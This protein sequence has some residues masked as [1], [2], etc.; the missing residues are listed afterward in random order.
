MGIAANPCFVALL[1][2]FCAF[3]TLMLLI[4]IIAIAQQF[5]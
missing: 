1:E 3:K 5:Q 2:R 4:Q